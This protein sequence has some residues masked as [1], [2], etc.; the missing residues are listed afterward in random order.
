[1]SDGETGKLYEGAQN[2]GCSRC[3]AVACL[4]LSDDSC[5]CA[6]YS[7]VSLGSPIR[8]QIDTRTVG[9]EIGVRSCEACIR[10]REIVGARIPASVRM[11]GSNI[12]A[13]LETR[14]GPWNIK[15]AR[16]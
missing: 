9:I 13:D 6:E 16:S 10:I 15:E 5:V 3:C 7:V 4:L 12:H 2:A 11:I 14:V 8:R 1:M